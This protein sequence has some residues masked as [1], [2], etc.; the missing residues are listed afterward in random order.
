M[1]QKN[2]IHNLFKDNKEKDK[3]YF[4]PFLVAGDP[5]TSKFI[6]LILALE[7][8][9]DILEIGIPF[10]D[11][12]ADGETVQEANLRAFKAGINTDKAIAAIK[13]IRKNTNKPIVVLTYYNILIQGSN[14]IE[15]ALDIT[16]GK[17]KAVGIDGI[18]IADLPVEEADLA[19]KMA[20]KYDISII[21][22]IA[23]ST[24]EERLNKILTVAD[25]F[26]YLISVM[27]ITGAR[28]SIE[29]ITKNTI[30]KVKRKIR[31]NFPIFL[32]FGISTP[33]HSQTIIKLGADGV[34]IGSAIIEIIKK[35][36][37]NFYL[38]KKQLI[39]FVSSIKD[40]ITSKSE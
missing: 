12:I 7:P 16:F 10:S 40:S 39:N 29:E 13:R 19:L 30:K 3:K 34:I 22:I 1:K 8:Y 32:G 5:S 4:M 15:H 28:K 17:M 25:G 36:L 31:D 26:L 6:E 14:T 37:D 35:N 23:P 11:P 2:R 38:M 20:K 18:V 9:A 27:G 24:T 33:N 21:F